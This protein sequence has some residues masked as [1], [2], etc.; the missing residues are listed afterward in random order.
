[1]SAFCLTC[2]IPAWNEAPRIARV[3][4]VALS[5]PEID[6][7]I[8]VDDGSTDETLA[9]AR[10][11]EA[12]HPRLRVL[13]QTRNGGKTQAVAR[14]VAEA[15]GT[16]LLLLDSD[17]IGLTPEALQALISPVEAGEADTSISLRRNAPA[18]WH[19]IGLDYISG[20]RVFPRAVLVERLGELARLPK[21][22]LEVYMNTLWLERGFSI[23]VVPWGGV[24]S[25]LKSAKAGVVA[26]GLA[27][28]AMLADIFR[29][30]GPMVVL[31]QI[32]RMRAQRVR[33]TGPQKAPGRGELRRERKR[34]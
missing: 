17:L 8:V 22:G 25:P 3:L 7:V 27:D 10:R 20:E 30:V 1:M 4:E 26:G 5:T 33:S 32:Y 24:S 12:D 19:W 11:F 31:R 34:A 14:G 9:V 6:E 21:F 13:A 23:A 28:V 2:I 16:H 15:T 29:T 18:P